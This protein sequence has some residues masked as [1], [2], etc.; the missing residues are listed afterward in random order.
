MNDEYI[1]PPIKGRPQLPHQDGT[2]SQDDSE[3]KIEDHVDAANAVAIQGDDIEISSDGTLS[4]WADLSEN[5][6]EIRQL[7]AENKRLRKENRR[8][9]AKKEKSTRNSHAISTHEFGFILFAGSDA[10]KLESFS[11]DEEDLTD[12]AGYPID[13]KE[14]PMEVTVDRQLLS[15]LAVPDSQNVVSNT[16]PSAQQALVGLESTS[17]KGSDLA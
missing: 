1:V 4:D 13:I 16:Y 5:Q 6:L 7:R 17:W 14:D 2:E 10:Y 9:R 3:I 8:L 15:S 11:S 12:I